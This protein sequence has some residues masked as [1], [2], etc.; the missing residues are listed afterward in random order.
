MTTL[1]RNILEIAIGIAYLIGALFGLLY[2]F[3]YGD[4]FFGSFAASAWLHPVRDIMRKFVIPNDQR[5]TLLLVFFQ[6]AVSIAILARGN[7]V[8]PGL[9]A[10]ALFA[11]LAIFVSNPSGAVANLCLA[12]LQVYLALRR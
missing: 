3:R 7:L 6:F 11:L 12:A 8:T 4:E 1:I 10:G 5:I 2:I 9:L